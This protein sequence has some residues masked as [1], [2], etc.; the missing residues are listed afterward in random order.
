MKQSPQAERKLTHKRMIQF[1]ITFSLVKMNMEGT[2]YKK[3]E[4]D[5]NRKVNIKWAHKDYIQKQPG[6]KSEFTLSP[7]NSLY[8]K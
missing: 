6:L 4:I 2:I 8:K 5:K 3:F 1:Q 7:L